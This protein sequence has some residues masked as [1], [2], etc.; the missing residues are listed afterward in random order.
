MIWGGA[1]DLLRKKFSVDLSQWKRAAV[2]QDLVWR[3]KV[4]LLRKRADAIHSFSHEDGLVWGRAV[5]LPKR[6]WPNDL[7]QW[8]WAVADPDLVWGLEE[9]LPRDWSVDFL[10]RE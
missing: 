7:S 8:K 3:K 2:G 1:V 4:D 6:E 9:D 5:D 10:T